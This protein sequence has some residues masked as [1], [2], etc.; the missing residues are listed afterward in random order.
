[1]YRFP[2]S[3]AVCLVVPLLAAPSAL[4]AEPIK[5]NEVQARIWV[6]QD[7]TGEACKPIGKL[8]E[9]I[10]EPNKCYRELDECPVALAAIEGKLDAGFVDLFVD[11]LRLDPLKTEEARNPWLHLCPGPGHNS[12]DPFL[13]RL[14]AKGLGYAG[15][16]D[17]VDVLVTLTSKD[18][19]A[20]LDQVL[21]SLVVEALWR[22]GNR[23][24]GAPALVS[25]LESGVRDNDPYRSLALQYLARWRV[26]AAAGYCQKV[27]A[28][29]SDTSLAK[30]CI[31]YLG[32]MKVK[33]AVPLLVR[34]MDDF[35]EETARALGQ[36]GDPAG[37]QALERYLELNDGATPQ[38]APALVAML[39]LGKTEHWEELTWMLGGHRSP[40]KAARAKFDPKKDI[41]TDERH[42]QRAA[43]ELV[44]LANPAFQTK[45]TKALTEIADEK[46]RGWRGRVFATIA[47]AE[48][49]HKPSI[50][51]LAQYLE[52]PS[53]DVRR[54]VLNAIGGRDDAPSTYF[55]E[56]GLGAIGDAAL[57][58]A[59]V[60]FL[61]VE[62]DRTTRL[63]ALRAAAN[64]K[65]MLQVP[66]ED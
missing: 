35:G 30:S 52:D 47:L 18:R 13:D 11:L 6:L 59:A 57:Q 46:G 66:G 17:K 9:L 42:V 28:S 34:N 33:E 49:G 1:M 64:I 53:K 62:S 37:I 19:F 39:N 20:N 40:R 38:R 65:A 16:K 4:A 50:E 48:R 31:S 7:K 10:E 23:E 36:I 3:A 55:W 60:K 32:W 25:T 22:A 58:R 21:R 24:K 61:S 56:R 5:L 63:T 14:A 51:A 2:M 43:M 8:E 44:L 12:V 45:V 54:A 29:K 15:S 27:L 41:L 26:D